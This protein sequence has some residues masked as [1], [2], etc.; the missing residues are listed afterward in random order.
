MAILDPSL[1][2]KSAAIAFASASL[3]KLPA[4]VWTMTL[5][6]KPSTKT[7]LSDGIFAC[8]AC[9]A[10]VAVAF[11]LSGASSTPSSSPLNASVL[12]ILP[13]SEATSICTGIMSPSHPGIA[14]RLGGAASTSTCSFSSS[15]EITRQVC[16]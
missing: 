4:Q 11:S 2:P 16:P 13:T 15:T 3:T 9:R 8:F 7:S 14:V 6:S 5:F 10:R 12:R 1:D